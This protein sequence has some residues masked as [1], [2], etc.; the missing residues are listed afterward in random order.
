MP[1]CN[2]SQA[3]YNQQPEKSLIFHEANGKL[4]PVSDEFAIFIKS[5]IEFKHNIFMRDNVTII[6]NTVSL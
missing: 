3:G 5:L 4:S 1:F 6:N 2:A